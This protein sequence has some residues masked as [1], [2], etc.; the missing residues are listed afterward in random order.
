MGWPAAHDCCRSPPWEVILLSPL[1]S[2]PNRV[3]RAVAETI[4]PPPQATAA[5]IRANGALCLLAALLSLV[6]GGG[7]IWAGS[8]IAHF[9]GARLLMVPAI[10]FYVLTIFG[11]Y[12]LIVGK[13]PAP[14]HPGEI[15]IKR[16]AFGIASV[17]VVMAALVGLIAI[18]AHFLA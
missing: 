17:L 14:S 7:A 10:L 11:A 4:V 9:H 1:I 13:S 18:A 5:Q 15:S 3:L 12:R 8:A 16:I 6:L 2:T